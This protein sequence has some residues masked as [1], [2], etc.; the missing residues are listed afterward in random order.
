MPKRF[1]PCKSNN[2]NYQEEDDE[3]MTKLMKM[4]ILLV[5]IIVKLCFLN[6]SII[7]SLLMIIWSSVNLFQWLTPEKDN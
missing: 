3:L 2:D 6:H 4:M 5:D 7:Q 1:A